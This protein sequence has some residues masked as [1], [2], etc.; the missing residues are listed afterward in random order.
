MFQE[1]ACAQL[2]LVLQL[3]L[4]LPQSSLALGTW[5]LGTLM[6]TLAPALP[7]A[8]L[9]DHP[10]APAAAK[11]SCDRTGVGKVS[12]GGGAARPSRPSLCALPGD[13]QMQFRILVMSLKGLSGL[14]LWG[15]W[16]S[17]RGRGR[18]TRHFLGA[19][20]IQVADIVSPVWR[21][22]AQ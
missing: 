12:G 6:W 20:I 18:C 11:G 22:P 13:F 3:Q 21:L 16:V 8:A 5:A 7:G 19:E 4:L 15:E 2:Q 14:A 17:E 9:A 1:G 10:E